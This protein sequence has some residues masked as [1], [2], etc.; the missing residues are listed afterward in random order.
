MQILN[1]GDQLV[2]ASPSLIKIRKNTFTTISH[3]LI[4]K[5]QLHFTDMKK[6]IH[7]TF[8]TAGLTH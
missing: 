3:L 4:I 1:W 6:S 2:T 8:T 5:I 7:G